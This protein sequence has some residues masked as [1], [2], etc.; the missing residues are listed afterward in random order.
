MD[1]SSVVLGWVMLYQHEG[2]FCQNLYVTFGHRGEEAGNSQ[3][4]EKWRIIP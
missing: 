1:Q 4:K 2:S 3:K